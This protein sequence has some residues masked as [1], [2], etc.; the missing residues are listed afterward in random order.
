MPVVDYCHIFSEGTKDLADT[1]LSRQRFRHLLTLRKSWH[2]FCITN[3]TPGDVCEKEPCTAI[4]AFTIHYPVF[5]VGVNQSRLCLYRGDQ[6]RRGSSRL[7]LP[8]TRALKWLLSGLQ[9]GMR[10]VNGHKD[11]QTSCRSRHFSPS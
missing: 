3:F 4:L 5:W 9:P 1:P 7:P 6:P 8:E 11:I 2:I 10:H